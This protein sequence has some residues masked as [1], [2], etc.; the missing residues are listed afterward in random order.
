[1]GTPWTTSPKPD[2]PPPVPE[3]EALDAAEGDTPPP[4]P[5]DG[6]LGKLDDRL[7]KKRLAKEA[8]DDEG[9]S[10][11]F[12]PCPS[13]GADLRFD[14]GTAGMR[15]GH[16]DETC[17]VPHIDDAA[18]QVENCYHYYLKI[19][20]SE[21]GAGAITEEEAPS[22]SCRGCG[23]SIEFH[24]DEHSRICPFCDAAIVGDVRMQRR[25]VP[26][27][28][29]P[30]KLME[31]EA[32]DAMRAWLK[33]RWFAPNDIADEA[34]ADHFHGIYVPFWTYDAYTETD[35]T[36]MRGTRTGTG[37]NRRTVWRKVSGHVKGGFDDVI[38]S[39]SKSVS[40]EFKDALAPWPLRHLETY[41]TEF[42][43]GFR[44]ENHM[45][46]LREG[47]AKAQVYMRALI[48]DWIKKDIG[49]HR[50]RVTSTRTK[51]SKETFKHI[52]VPVW[53]THYDFAG[54]TYRLSVNGHTAKAYGQRPFSMTKLIIGS[55]AMLLAVGVLGFI[56]SSAPWAG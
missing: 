24:E 37:K 7:H 26:Q 10:N 44:A 27:G 42:L 32:H 45:I 21:H 54:K 28:V 39:G 55:A 31:K 17:E 50:Q 2:A 52:L 1:M 12:F 13:C 38:V 35:Y 16:C 11:R 19:E 22:L 3:A 29:L 30:F 20:A 47:F 48:T 40:V 53:I 15:C 4:V 43:A 49:G 18:A 6:T 34:R 8:A 41:Q 25:I 51:F 56:I 9:H 36:G 14:P 5:H 46:G 23:S 33:S